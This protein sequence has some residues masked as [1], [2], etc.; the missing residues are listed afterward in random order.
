MTGRIGSAVL[1]VDDFGATVQLGREEWGVVIDAL[2]E[3]QASASGRKS[4]NS[5]STSDVRS[6]ICSGLIGMLGD[7]LSATPTAP[8][9]HTCQLP[10]I[11]TV[12][13]PSSFNDRRWDCPVCDA[14]WIAMGR[15]VGRRSR[16]E[17]HQMPVTKTATPT[18]E[19]S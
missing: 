11:A 1:K 17:W 2:I 7:A 8:A 6:G 12:R 14:R 19:M 3:H 4:V 18:E 15:I 13:E 16:Y 9:S 10:D 5:E